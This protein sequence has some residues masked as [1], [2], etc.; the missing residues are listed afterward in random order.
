ME[1]DAL[2][3]LNDNIHSNND[4]HIEKKVDGEY[5]K[6][7]IECNKWCSLNKR[8]VGRNITALSKT[9]LDNVRFEYGE[10][11]NSSEISNDDEI[12]DVWNK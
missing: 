9:E 6:T 12:D 3:L 7:V 8:V 5:E 10:I 11:V 1:D 4:K 2:S